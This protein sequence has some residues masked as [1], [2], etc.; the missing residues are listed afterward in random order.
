ME[1]LNLHKVIA[2]LEQIEA[3]NLHMKRSLLS[4]NKY[5]KHCSDKIYNF[6]IKIYKKVNI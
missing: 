3:L 4:N 1:V 2:S 5:T 6:F